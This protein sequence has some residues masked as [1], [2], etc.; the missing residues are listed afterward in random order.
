MLPEGGLSVGGLWEQIGSGK[1]VLF[2]KT[3]VCVITSVH[4]FQ[5]TQ[6]PLLTTHYRTLYGNISKTFLFADP[7]W[8]RKIT[9][10]TSGICNNVLHD[11]T[12][13][14]NDFRS[15]RRYKKLVNYIS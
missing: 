14:K 9:I 8:L 3:R 10:H 5:S 13:L 11:F 15:L 2:L 4:H 7:F 12:L 6:M 1:T